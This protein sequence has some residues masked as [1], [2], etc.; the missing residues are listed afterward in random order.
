M[1]D[2]RQHIAERLAAAGHVVDDAVVEELAQH[3]A[4]AF[5]AARA[6]GLTVGDADARVAGLVDGWVAHGAHLRH[7]HHAAAV[8]PPPAGSNLLAGILNDIRYACRLAW[9]R[10]GP[11]L[12]AALTM[13]LGI[14]A[15][16]TLFSVTWGV[17]MKPLPWPEPETIVRLQ[18]TRQGATRSFPRIMTNG[19]LLAWAD[20][21]TTIEAVAA[22]TPQTVT[23]TA[24]GGSHRVRISA[25]TASLFSVLRAVPA[26]GRLLT[27]ADEAADN[28]TV[29]SHAFWIR[30]LGGAT[31][32][33]GTSVQF[34]GRSYE[35]AGVLPEDFA[36][37]DRD[38][39]AWTPYRVR[40]SAAPDG[41]SYIQLFSA[42]ARL[43]PGVTP[44]QAAQEATSRAAAAP[45]PGV[46]AIAVFG[47]KGAAEVTAEPI[48]DAVTADVREALWVLLAAVALLLATATAN[49]ASVQL[50]RAATRRREMAVRSAIGA[51]G[52]RLA[53]QLIVESLVVGAA[54]GLGGLALSVALH[55]ALPAL[56][57]A[58][59][60][61]IAD[62]SLDAGVMAFSFVVALLAS[63]AFGLAPALQARRLDLRSGL[64][65]DAAATG[66]GFGR[67]RT[68]RARA[69]IMAGQVAVACVLLVGASLLVRTFVAMLNVERGYDPANVLTAR[70]ATPN[71]LFSDERRAA[72]VSR[73]LERLRA[74]P[75]V[76]KAGSTNVLPLMPGGAMMALNLPE[77]PGQPAQTINTGFRVVSPGYFEAMGIALREGRT[78]DERDTAAAPPA[79]VVNRAFAQKYL[80]D[81]ATG[82]RLPVEIYEGLGNWQVA[83]VVDDVR[84]RGALTEPAQ[85]EMFVAYPQVPGGMASQP[86]LVIRTRGNPALLVE[87]LRQIVAAE[88]PSAALESVMTMEERVLGS[89]ARPRL[90]ALVLAGFAAFALAI[91]AVGLFGVLSY[92]VAQRS[93]ELG[94]R[95]ALGARPAQIVALVLREG[96]VICAAGIVAGLGVAFI[97]TSW[98]STF[99]YGVAPRDVLT[100]VLVPAA[101]L[102]VAA[103]ACAVPARRAARLDPLRVLRSS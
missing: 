27:A 56:L 93:R 96:L 3:A 15:A 88:E 89:L 84:M 79:L 57:P 54:G 16:T 83:G 80:A 90:Y 26:R 69:M 42:V 19:T 55:R 61:R 10:P 9:R 73:A 76:L 43:K 74:R 12:V 71:G 4:G 20:S 91:A 51:G 97:A 66:A 18:E 101:L 28:V 35:I 44:A 30:H 41:G 38:T 95:A 75:D 67:S 94:V 60:P 86:V 102:A 77:L 103:I 53:R 13:A 78:F 62:I 58:D 81:G 14:G 11:A 1:R 33:V 40:P 65:D 92:S 82:R 99:L 64:T 85:P 59:F 22:Y 24:S 49:V 87:A 6:E 52:G 5:T 2:L 25:A 45:D 32:V 8:E 47:S 68:A 72:L 46:A 7:R 17:L 63:L 31:N 36:F 70:I 29:V 39:L 37:P 100:F 21:P 50:A 98:L 23:M 34:D 48:L